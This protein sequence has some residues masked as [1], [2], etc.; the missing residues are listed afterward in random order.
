MKNLSSY[1][2]WRDEPFAGC[3]N[4]DVPMGKWLLEHL[5]ARPEKILDVGCGTGLHTEWFNR[6]GIETWGITINRE[7]IKKRRHKNVDFGDM[8]NIPFG[9]EQFDCVFALGSVEHTFAPFVALCEFNRVLKPGG[10][11]FFDMPNIYNMEVMDPEY[12]YHK[13]ILFPIQV[14]DLLLKSQFR[15]HEHRYAESINETMYSA[16]SAAIYLAQK[17]PEPIRWLKENM[18]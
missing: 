18:T 13:S 7:E 8:C 2:A 15:L 14:R 4:P 10:W 6:Q 9:A 3:E 17:M 1:E 12:W 16:D 11:L 5:P